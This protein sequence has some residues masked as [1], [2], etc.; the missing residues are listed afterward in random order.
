MQQDTA[1]FWSDIKTLDAR[2]TENP[3]SLC[4]AQLADVY[5]KVGLIDDAVHLA[6]RGVERHPRYL[7]GQRS[8]AMACNAKG[9]LEECRVALEQVTCSLPEDAVSQKMLARIYLQEGKTVEA[10]HCFKTVLEFSPDDTESLIQIAALQ[11][12]S[13]IEQPQPEVQF[14]SAAEDEEIEELEET[15]I[16]EIDDLD[17]IEDVEENHPLDY[18]MALSADSEIRANTPPEHVDP[19]STATLAELYVKQ[20]FIEKALVIYRAVLADNPDN[21]EVSARVFELEHQSEPEPENYEQPNSIT[22]ENSSL[23]QETIS[24]PPESDAPSDIF[25]A[26]TIVPSSG[27]A[28]NA[29]STL[30]TWLKNIRRIKSCR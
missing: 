9:L 28:D 13:T 21:R 22:E 17:I 1:S 24:V 6:R 4:F 7:A 3:E 10:E 14:L 27:C 15:D 25:A 29:V 11:P 30:N 26:D 2:L 8:L 5:L 23:L 20:G 12:V 19:L 18:G 16:L